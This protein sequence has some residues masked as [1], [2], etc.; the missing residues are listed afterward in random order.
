MRTPIRPPPRKL[1]FL[2]IIF[3]DRPI[4]EPDVRF[5]RNP[6]QRDERGRLADPDAHASPLIYIPIIIKCRNGCAMPPGRIACPC[7][8]GDVSRSDNAASV[9]RSDQR[10]VRVGGGSTAMGTRGGGGIRLGPL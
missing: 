1:V 7:A 6:E 4:A 8:R 5:R 3:S 10:G 9:K 2:P